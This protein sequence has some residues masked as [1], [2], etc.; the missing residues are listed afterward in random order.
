MKSPTSLCLP[1]LMSLVTLPVFNP[2]GP[3]EVQP[4]HFTSYP[5]SYLKGTTTKFAPPPVV[6]VIDQFDPTGAPV[7]VK[8][9]PEGPVPPDREDPGYNGDSHHESGCPPAL[10][11]R[12]SDDDH[13][14]GL[15]PEPVR[16]R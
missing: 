14:P 7:T 8:G 15:G 13:Q 9:G 3:T 11:R 6:Q 5:V 10:L 16:D 1:S 2:P 4:D 12:H